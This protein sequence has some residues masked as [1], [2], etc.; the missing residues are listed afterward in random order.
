M[1]KQY[2]FPVSSYQEVGT[3]DIKRPVECLGFKAYD[4]ADYFDC[5][6]LPLYDSTEDIKS[7]VDGNSLMTSVIS[8]FSYEFNILQ[9]GNFIFKIKAANNGDN[10]SKLTNQQIDYILQTPVDGESYQITADGT[11]SV[12]EYKDDNVITAGEKYDMFRSLIFSVYVDGEDVANKKGYVILKNNDSSQAL[13]S[14]VLI[15]NLTPGRHV[16]YLHFLSDYYYNF[17]GQDMPNYINNFAGIDLNQD[18]TLDVN[19]VI[20]SV[21]VNSVGPVDDIIG[22]RIYTN[23]KNK[24]P[25]TWYTENVKNP[26]SQIEQITIDGYRAVRDD[27]TIYVHAANLTSEKF[28]SGGDN[29]KKP[30]A[31]EEECSDGGGTCKSVKNFFTNIY[32]IAY[33]QNAAPT[34]VNIFNQMLANWVFNKN[35]LEG[36]TLAEAEKIKDKLRRDTIRKSDFTNMQT[37]LENYKASYNKYPE[38]EAG[39]FVKGHSISTWPS[40]QATLG[41]QLG[42]AL[43]VD[44]LNI[45]N[46]EIKGTYDCTDPIEKNNCLNVCAR[47]ASSVPLTG[48]PKDKQCLENQYCS[49][50]PPGYDA[51]TCW[52]S[53]NN[54][55]AYPQH[56]KCSDPALNGIYNLGGSNCGYDGAYVYQYYNG[57][58]SMRFEYTEEDACAANYCYFDNDNGNPNDDCYQPGACLYDVNDD[59]QPENPNYKDLYCYIGSWRKSCGDGFLAS[60]CGEECE[61]SIAIAE[62]EHSWCDINYGDQYWYNEKNIK[63]TCGLPETATACAWEGIDPL[64]KPA[65]FTPNVA[66]VDCGGFCGDKVIEAQY[67]EKCD[68]GL[69]PAPL[70]TPEKNGSGGVSQASQYLC[71]GINTG[72]ADMKNGVACDKYAGWEGVLDDCTN[73]TTDSGW[74]QKFNENNI[75]ALGGFKASYNFTISRSGN[76]NFKLTASN[77]QDNLNELTNQQIDYIINLKTSNS[78]V[79]DTIYDITADGGLDIAEYGPVASI[80]AKKYELLRSLIFSVYLDGEADVN[81]I[82][83]LILPATNTDQ[84]QE[85]IISLGYLSA[86]DHTIYLHFIGDHFYIPLAGLTSL[87]DFSNVEGA[88]GDFTLDINP[89]IYALSIFSPELGVGNCQTFGGWC[90]DGM[91]QMEFGEQCDLKN[92][93]TPGPEQTVNLIKNPGFE[94]IFA[95]WEVNQGT[96]VSLDKGNYIEGISSLKLTSSGT[97]NLRQ[98]SVVFGQKGYDISLRLKTNSGEVSNIAF[99]TGNQSASE[100]WSGDSADFTEVPAKAV[101]GWK[102]YE[103]KNYKPAENNYKIRFIFT[104]SALSE[105]NIDDLQL[106]PLDNAVRPQYQCGNEPISGKICQFRGGFCGDGTIQTSF[107]E[108]C[109]DR[110]GLSCSQSSD[111]GAK[112]RCNAAK[113]CES[114]KCNNLCKST[115]CGDGIPQTPNSMGVNEICDWAADPLCANDCQHIKMGGD[116]TDIRPCASSLSCTIR[117]FGDTATKCLGARASYGCRANS[118]CILGYYCNIS[119]TRCEPEI[120]TYLRYHPENIK[121]LTLPAPSNAAYDI[122][123]TTCPDIRYYLSVDEEKRYLYDQCS[124]NLWA[125]T[126]NLSRNNWTYQ[127]ALADACGGVDRLPTI[128]ELYSLVKQTNSD[129]LYA[130]KD[131]LNLCPVACTYDLNSPNYCASCPDDNYLY[132]SSSCVQKD[133]GGACQKALVVNFKYGSI[134]E[135]PTVDNPATANY[136]EQAKFKVRCLKDVQCGNGNIEEGET[137]EFYI[138]ADSRL[139]EQEISGQC[140]SYGYDGGF[141]HCDPVTCNY[142]FDNCYFNSI[143]NQ[144]CA[145]TCLDKKALG[146]KS[147]GLNIDQGSDIYDIPGQ[148]LTIANDGLL[149]DVDFFGNCLTPARNIDCNYNFVNRQKNCRDT[150]SNQ[151][152]SFVSEYAYCNCAE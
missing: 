73:L 12:L 60:A 40:W 104:T 89:V 91:V 131:L 135:Y 50:C 68:E 126:D 49:I 29:D 143:A 9:Q 115:F 112:G 146:C 32:V 90:G 26:S 80:D 94:G 134:E 123:L 109:D 65:P 124:G 45:M 46:T 31:L 41:N 110:V 152:Q 103:I 136:N 51:K 119:T 30:C 122:N 79:S 63:A 87:P 82:G 14:S 5:K 35:V 70:K 23:K 19:P 58:I 83:Y 141:L 100:E 106:Q 25:R 144:S 11:L 64:N 75:L 96:T 111:C 20:S 108:T 3:A 107:G 97:V 33:N 8:K 130:D 16:V 118:D 139:I 39:T 93:L 102:Y 85:K 36:K 74:V 43:P 28:C 125:G 128:T 149:M 61:P 1:L 10:F 38:L 148:N 133:A 34:T 142:K 13:E 151:L 15:G 145:K 127:E 55:F 129:F 27:R 59:G 147:V 72:E 53:V 62:G 99:Q 22:I 95:P 140:A 81:K 48:C 21:G 2:L 101:L 86:D 4:E 137:C 98:S 150:L 88:N 120:S 7:W 92:Y 71:S 78:A 117:N 54:K 132:W 44:P 67:G 57:N 47:D 24:D 113:V 66:D 116:C 37:L 56:F 138:G 76:F 6:D 114:D 18:Q 105:F 84:K 52:D 42:S 69:V 121:S 77:D 17:S